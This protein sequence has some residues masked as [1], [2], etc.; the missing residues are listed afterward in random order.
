VEARAIPDIF[1]HKFEYSALRKS[2]KLICFMAV[3]GLSLPAY[4]RAQRLEKNAGN[5]DS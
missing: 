1:A 3:V 2:S 5:S 4:L